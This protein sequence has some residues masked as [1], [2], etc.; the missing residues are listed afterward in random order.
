MLKTEV[1]RGPAGRVLVMNSITQVEP[2]DEGCLVVSSSH[3]G[4][5]SGEF[6]LE[7]PLALAVFNDAGV[8]KDDAGIAALAMLQARGVPAATVAHTS[9]RIGDSLDTWESGVVSHANAAAR[10]RGITPGNR[11][12]AAVER[13]IAGQGQ[14]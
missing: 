7:V 2:E 3:G 13:W 6:A 12:R 5:S 10:A 11:L 8:G 1:A 9:A 4:T 14:P